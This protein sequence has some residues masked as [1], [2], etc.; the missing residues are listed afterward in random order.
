MTEVERLLSFLARPEPAK[1][2]EVRAGLSISAPTLSRLIRAAGSDVC[3]LG[4][5]RSS[6][7][8]RTRQVEGLPRVLPVSRVDEHGR[9]VADGT[10][11][12]LWKGAHLRVPAHGRE[13]FFV[14]LP[15]FLFDMAP[16]GYLG[17][18][19]AS[20][21]TELG[22]PSRIADWNDDH[23]LV[24]TARRGFDFPG[25]YLVGNE[26]LQRFLDW[27]PPEA[28]RAHFV[29]LGTASASALPGSSAGGE[30]PKFCAFVD[31][32]HCLVKFVANQDTASSRRWQELLVCEHT[33]LGVVAKAG[34]SASQSK[35]VERQGWRFLEAQRFDRE[36]A[37]G[38]RD[39]ISLRALEQEFFGHFDTW[40]AAALRLS[41]DETFRLPE[42][43]ARRLRWLDVFGQLIANTDR[44]FGNV[45]FL[46]Q[47]DST[48]RL[49]PAYD[50]LPMALAPTLLGTTLPAFAA[51]PPNAENLDIW[52]DAA[53]W[54]RAYWNELA[55]DRGLEGDLRTF[56]RRATEDISR[57]AERV[58]GTTP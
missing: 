23:R 45:S 30:Q 48:L 24:A 39:V 40:S 2:R 56:A 7:Y 18:S 20:G 54:A 16:Q 34:V 31:G 33:A 17:R 57:M 11:T 12:T 1:A 25:N 5:G 32:A 9:V 19:I 14:G 35:L 22:L 13:H 55:S 4:D 42:E 38:R 36:G 51:S 41:A 53:R 47:A 8:M 43:D 49:A 21:L 27:N 6:A 52:E 46:V 3:R 28:T 50:M 44:H 15:P 26:A 29:A 58:S 10:L 37:R